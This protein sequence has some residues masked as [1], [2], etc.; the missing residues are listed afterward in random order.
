MRILRLSANQDSFHPV[1]FRR[2]GISLVLA[3]KKSDDSASTE[4]YNGVGKSLLL[5][6]LHYCLGSNK[7]KAF[8]TH[9]PGWVFSLE[10]EIDGTEHTITRGAEDSNEITLDGETVSLNDLRAFLKRA[11]LEDD[12]VGPHL[13]FRSM[14]PRFI[15]VGKAAYVEFRFASRG[16]SQSPYGPMLRNAALLGLDLEL[17]RKKYDLRTRYQ[18]FDKTMKQLKS[19]PLFERLVADDTVDIQLVTLQD[20]AHRLEENLSAFQVA[21][22]YHE[23][24]IEANSAKRAL[25]LARRE[26][27]K[28]RNALQQIEKSLQMPT[29]IA[30]ER[31]TRAYEE[32]KVALPEAVVR[33]IEEVVGFQRELKAKRAYRLSHE[34]RA[35]QRELEDSLAQVRELSATLDARTR[36]L[37]EHR[38]IDEYF[39][40]NTQLDDVRRQITELAESKRLKVEVQCEIRQIESNLAAESVRT[41]EYLASAG[42]LIDSAMAAF[43]SFAQVLYGQRPS[44]LT[45]SNDDGNNQQRYRIE[46][47]IKA[48]AA[49]GIN[50]AK[51]F[52]FDMTALILERGH[53]F[54]FLAH[55]SSLFSPVDPRQQFAMFKT[56]Q[57]VCQE[58]DFQYIA[59]LNQHDV[60]SIREESGA[61]EDEIAAI[62]APENVVLTLTDADPSEMLLGIEVDMKYEQ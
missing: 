2:R 56:A 33:S 22:D 31:V 9:L 4:T 53:R 32:A 29:D 48:D 13:T 57:Q 25:D 49:E 8:E 50:E 17:A 40:V 5:V 51:I 16:E 26:E 30:V 43:R 52:C 28:V 46:A 20:E 1:E 55:D 11:T 39:A 61:S 42:E 41:D 34:K 21:E 36:F 19:E 6:L 27:V 7:I 54:Q 18:R 14:C 35:L 24:E 62:F 47:H 23:I 44:G 12:I 58:H 37:S 10:V 3:E 59:T 45:V 15:R 60:V 38:A